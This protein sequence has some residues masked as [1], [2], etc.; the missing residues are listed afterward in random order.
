M[1]GDSPAWRN[2]LLDPNHYF[3]CLCHLAYTCHLPPTYPYPTECSPRFWSCIVTSFITILSHYVEITYSSTEPLFLC[4]TGF[5][6]QSLAVIAYWLEY[7]RP[8][9]F[10]RRWSDGN[11]IHKEVSSPSNLISGISW[12]FLHLILQTEYSFQ[13]WYLLNN[14]LYATFGPSTNLY[15]VKHNLFLKA[16]NTSGK[17]DK[18]RESKAT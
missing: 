6:P 14:H 3:T 2:T 7:K 17:C 12:L 18:L 8:L 1:G 13:H 9:S 16:A 15:D 4:W 10:R 11:H 5:L